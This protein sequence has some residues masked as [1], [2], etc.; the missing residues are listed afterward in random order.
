MDPSR[1]ATPLPATTEFD[2]RFSP[3]DHQTQSRAHRS[4]ITKVALQLV[5]ANHQLTPSL[6]M[7]FRSYSGKGGRGLFT[8]YVES[9]HLMKLY[10]KTVY[11]HESYKGMDTCQPK[12]L[13]H[14]YIR[15]WKPQV[16]MIRITKPLVILILFKYTISTL[17]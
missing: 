7:A 3:G 14:N 6:Y 12:T 17:G 10:P 2:V 15:R 11:E 5:A 1:R 9:S 16:E 13:P 4:N 8:G